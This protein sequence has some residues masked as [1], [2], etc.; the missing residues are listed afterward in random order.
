[1]PQDD[2]TEKPT[3]KRRGE[4]REKGQIA[5]S[6]DLS[7]A[8]V[9]L[10][11][12]IGV[13]VLGAGI[14]HGTGSAMSNLFSDIARPA[15]VSSG[16]GL[17][18]L[19]H[20]VESTVLKAVGP[21]FGMCLIAALLVNLAQTRLNFS[22]KAITPDFKKLNPISGAKRIFGPNALFETAKAIVK[23]AVVGGVVAMT[24][25]PDMTH[26]KASVG[27]APADLA[28]MLRT[29][30]VGIAM[31]A[32]AGY[33]LIGLADYAWQRHETEK[34][35]KMTKQEVRE[36]AK[37]KDLP[38]EVKSA[39]RRR[40]I[41]AARSRMM[42][43]VP[44]A[45]VVVTNPT[46]FAVALQ[47]SGDRPAPVVIAKGQDNVALAIRRIATENNIPIVENR[48]LARELHRVVEI[49]QMI[50]SELYSAVAEVLAFVY[51]MAARKRIGV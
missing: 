11:G 18:G 42:A 26:L 6:H 29:N 27:T 14:A 31:R 49:D 32:G 23:V 33:L 7:G 3:A 13:G 15:D 16:A 4:A 28:T 39:I 37:Q 20:L 21:L 10:T 43:A 48:P 44:Q 9:T 51:R 22:P 47:Y 34:S 19:F 35:L 50:P 36:E 30:I 46:H 38:P 2:K 12:L 40:Q 1:M 24:L 41:Q 17:H 8:V 5:K 45:D 25:I